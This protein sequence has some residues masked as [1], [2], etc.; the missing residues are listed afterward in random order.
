MDQDT[1]LKVIKRAAANQ[2]PTLDRS[3]K[4][5]TELHA[6]RQI[7]DEVEPDWSHHACG[8]LRKILTPEGHYL[9]LCDHHAQKYAY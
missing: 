7:L 3:D 5:L 8:G 2:V 6:L 9:W 1:L 4:Q